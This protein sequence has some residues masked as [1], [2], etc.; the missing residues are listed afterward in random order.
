[1]KSMCR[2]PPDQCWH[3]G[4]GEGGA[5]ILSSVTQVA[6]C[7][8]LMNPFTKKAGVFYNLIEFLV[9]G[10]APILRARFPPFSPPSP[11]PPETGRDGCRQRCARW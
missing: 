4:G 2:A 5:C 3:D 9:H 11:P 8:P 6:P 10:N 1:M 7:F